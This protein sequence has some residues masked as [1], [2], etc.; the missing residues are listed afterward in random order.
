MYE[1]DILWNSAQF[2]GK[3]WNTDREEHTHRAAQCTKNTNPIYCNSDHYYIYIC[4]I[5]LQV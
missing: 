3:M 5:D 4:L 1:N 2:S